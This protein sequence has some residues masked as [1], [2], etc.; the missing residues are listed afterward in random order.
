MLH[1]G[2]CGAR[3]VVPLADSRMLPCFPLDVDSSVAHR[4]PCRI[5]T[6]GPDGVKHRDGLHMLHEA[7]MCVEE[8]LIRVPC[9]IYAHYAC[10]A[11]CADAMA[12]VW[13]DTGR[14]AQADCLHGNVLKYQ[15]T[16][17]WG[18]HGI[19]HIGS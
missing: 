4:T 16:V 13:E 1:S 12:D 10:K 5:R 14:C 7:F 15:S 19:V 2:N 9:I 3:L 8:D 18:L 17:L 6:D 11:D